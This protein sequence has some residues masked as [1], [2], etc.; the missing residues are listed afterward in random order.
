MADRG[1]RE[2]I[3]VDGNI[4]SIARMYDYY[5]GG[6][7]NFAADRAAADHLL[8]TAPE[9]VAIA[10]ENRAFLG[11]VVRYLAR[12]AGISQFLD[13]GTGLPTRDN[14]HQVAQR[15]S[16]DS[17]VVYVDNDAVVLA[18]ARALL[19]TDPRTVVVGADL[20]EPE[21]ILADPDVRA[22]LDFGRPIALL[23]VAIL[24]FVSD[25]DRPYEVV[26]RLR[27]A[28]PP[29]SHLALSHVVYEHHPEAIDRAEEV[30]RGFL[31]RTGHARRTS[32]DVRRFFGDWELADPGLTYVSGWRPK[33]PR[34][35]TAPERLW[36][37]GGVARKP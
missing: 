5:L 11:R 15:E 3:G 28:M 34:R 6:K 7:D 32:D 23:L 29:G 30:Y 21:T 26:A 2:P 36:I 31:H 27:D 1:P 12:E 9:I 20:L 35:S 16:P 10:R 37:V 13:I 19:A 8:E 14:V 17:Q 18:H 22:H 25:D 24:H 33:G 4:P